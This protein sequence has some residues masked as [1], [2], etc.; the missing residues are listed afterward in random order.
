MRKK[1]FAVFE[2]HTGQK[3]KERPT[4]GG[5]ETAFI[6]YG[7]PGIDIVCLGADCADY[8]TVKE[9][10]DLNSFRTSYEILKDMLSQL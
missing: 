8:H 10:L 5:L 2:K 1:L 4:H 3:M 9:S 6:S 7:I